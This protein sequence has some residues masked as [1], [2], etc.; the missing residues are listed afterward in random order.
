VT[1]T[2]Q[3]EQVLNLCATLGSHIQE[4]G[5]LLRCM[6]Q[7]WDQCTSAF[8]LLQ[9]VYPRCGLR[10]CIHMLCPLQVTEDVD[11]KQLKSIHPVCCH[12]TKSQLLGR[13]LATGPISIS[14]VSLLLT[15]I[16]CWAA[17]WASSWTWLHQCGVINMSQA[18]RSQI[19]SQNEK[20]QRQRARYIKAPGQLKPFRQDV[21]DLDSLT[22][23][24][25]KWAHG[26]NSGLRQTK[27]Q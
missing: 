24:S 4:F 12:I 20:R 17:C 25:Q 19:V 2:P 3:I 10:D 16:L 26:S 9:E 1:Q 11:S 14:L 18:G 8:E 7:V 23:T 15:F 22:S 13:V 21:P 27:S 5:A 6:H